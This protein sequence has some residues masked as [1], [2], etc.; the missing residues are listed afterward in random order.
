MNTVVFKYSFMKLTDIGMLAALLVFG[1]LMPSSFAFMPVDQPQLRQLIAAYVTGPTFPMLISYMLVRD[2]ALNQRSLNDGE[3][4]ALL[5]SRPVI[6]FQYIISKWLAN[7]IIVSAYALVGLTCYAIV[8]TALHK[9]VNLVLSPYTFLD[10]ILNSISFTALII[11]VNAMPSKIGIWVYLAALY[12][13]MFTS[14]TPMM[15][16]APDKFMDGAWASNLTFYAGSLQQT[17][18]LPSA[19]TFDALQSTSFLC[20]AIITYASNLTL[21]LF[22]ATVLLN[23][24]E[25]SYASD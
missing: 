25:F 23:K 7:S 3:Y 10:V 8:T 11:L 24:R 15:S 4:L 6:R 13:V 19:D 14:M 1:I 17:F 2:A 16:I 9:D 5:F 20:V 21:Y 22:L 12:C 18:I